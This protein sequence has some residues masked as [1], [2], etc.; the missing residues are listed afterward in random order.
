M[1]NIYNEGVEVSKKIY[2]LISER[3]AGWVYH[4]EESGKYIIKIVCPG[5]SE[6]IKQIIKHNS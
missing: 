4:R 3:F 6:Q 2:K 5:Y 1:L